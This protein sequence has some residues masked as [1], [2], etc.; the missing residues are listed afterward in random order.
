MNLCT[1]FAK[2]IGEADPSKY[3]IIQR[4]MDHNKEWR[5]DKEASW[6]VYNEN[7]V[8]FLLDKC[9]LK[10]QF[11]DE[12]IFHCLGVLDVNSVKINSGPQVVNGHGLYP[13][14]SLLS[15]SCKSNKKVYIYVSTFDQTHNRAC[16]FFLERT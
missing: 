11:T 5:Q 10:G 14:T 8:S 3:A 16:A 7:V 4:M 1:F 9:G 6:S 2:N 12:E 13:L 15:H